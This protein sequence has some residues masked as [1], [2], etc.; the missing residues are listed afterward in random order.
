MHC[1]SSEMALDDAAGRY[2]CVFIQPPNDT[3]IP[4]RRQSHDLRGFN[5]DRGWG[6]DRG[7]G[8]IERH[9]VLV[10][11]V[12]GQTSNRRGSRSVEGFSHWVKWLG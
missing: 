7:E 1:Y 5:A 4:R 11:G 12:I 3:V 2:F 8:L 9:Q 6:G 10:V